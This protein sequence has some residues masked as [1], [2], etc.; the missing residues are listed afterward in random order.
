MIAV[1]SAAVVPSYH[2]Q[3]PAL[4]KAY[5]PAP[6]Y[7]KAVVAAPVYKQEV[8]KQEVYPDT[9]AEYEFAYE[10]N[11]EHTGD[12]KSQKE[13]R[14]GDDVQ[15]EYS[16]IDADGYRRTVTY[17]ADEHHGFQATVRREPIEGFKAIV[18]PVVKYAAAPVQ[19]AAPAYK[20][21]AAPVHYAAPAYK[22]AAAPVHYAAPA[23]KV[24][25]VHYTAP[26]YKVAT[27]VAYAAPAYKVA[28]TPA[29]KVAAVPTYAHHDAQTHVNFQAPAHDYHY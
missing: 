27:P 14:K 16:L 15:G 25:P 7:A 23:Y 1:A 11:D 9:P 22:V 26:T 24:A 5:Q 18:A 3:Q 2:A 6:V 4:F 12:V 20:V 8:Y 28:A 21:A 19:Y 13:S 10:V 29:Y 17:T